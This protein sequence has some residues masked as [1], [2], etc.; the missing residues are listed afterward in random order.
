MKVLNNTNLTLREAL[1]QV[2]PQ[3]MNS[4][5]QEQGV[6][7]I[8]EIAKKPQLAKVVSNPG[9]SNNP[10]QLLGDDGISYNVNVFSDPISI[11]YEVDKKVELGFNAD[12]EP[13]Y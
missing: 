13:I 3:A 12:N 11:S 4:A 1:I 8:A 10:I 7:S 2:I 6:S 5:L 9:F